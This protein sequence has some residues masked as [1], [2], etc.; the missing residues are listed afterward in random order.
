MCGPS[1]LECCLVFGSCCF[2]S[3]QGGAGP[4]GKG[5]GWGLGGKGSEGEK[6]TSPEGLVWFQGW[7][8]GP[9]EKGEVLTPSLNA[10]IDLQENW[11]RLSQ[12]FPPDFL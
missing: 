12:F 7:V 10:L 1:P 3:D 4:G 11:K 2:P 5:L 8:S 9:E 6:D